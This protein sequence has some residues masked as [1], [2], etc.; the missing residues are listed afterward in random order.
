[1]ECDSSLSFAPHSWLLP[2]YKAVART[3]LCES[4][5]SVHPMPKEHRFLHL[6]PSTRNHDNLLCLKQRIRGRPNSRDRTRE[7][8]PLLRAVP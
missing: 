3:Y 5:R 1:M 2:N 6:H 4:L 7:L 8:Y